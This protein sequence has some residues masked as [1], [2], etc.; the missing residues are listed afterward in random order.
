MG[1]AMKCET[2]ETSPN[3]MKAS[4]NWRVS[5]SGLKSPQN[6]WKWSENKATDCSCVENYHH[7]GE[8]IKQGI[9]LSA[10]SCQG[11]KHI[12]LV[13]TLPRPP[14]LPMAAPCVLITSVL[15]LELGEVAQ[16]TFIGCRRNRFAITIVTKY[17]SSARKCS[18]WHTDELK[19]T[20]WL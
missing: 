11:E 5:I 13:S 10:M 4:R 16:F 9:W 19:G 8:D 12:P 15:F 17:N 7:F 14:E 1:L 3:A 2:H 6:M 18:Y 20:E